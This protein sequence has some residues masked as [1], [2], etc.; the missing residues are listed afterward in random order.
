MLVR[1]TGFTLIELL[2][3]IAIIAILAALLFPVLT[4]AKAKANQTMCANNLH[5]IGTAITNYADDWQGRLP[6]LNLYNNLADPNAEVRKGLLWR[7]VK[8]KDVFG[9][10]VEMDHTKVG[11]LP[12]TYTMNGY[13]TYAETDRTLANKAGVPVSKS[14][15]PTRTILIVDENM[16]AHK[17]PYA[18]N[19]ALFIWS[20]AT[21]DRH[22]G[23]TKKING[24]TG[25][26]NVCYLDTHVGTV[27]GLLVWDR[28]KEGDR[29]FQR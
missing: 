19:D 27:P 7:Y 26:A 6:G 13:M 28:D 12:F 23:G 8:S 14:Q 4:S 24:S 21:C 20:D 11:R 5:Q 22:P 9:C 2:V 16:D 15:N 1:K 29:I 10:P 18:V 3:V 17:N 25:C